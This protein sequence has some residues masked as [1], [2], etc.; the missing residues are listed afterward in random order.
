MKIIFDFDNTLFDRDG[1]MQAVAR[2]FGFS[3]NDFLASYHHHF[4][5]KNRFYHS[6]E[7]L[8]ILR[9]QEGASLEQEKKKRELDHLLEGSAEFLYSYSIPALRAAGDSGEEIF[10]LSEGDQEFQGAKINNCGIT[11]FFDKIMVTEDKIGSLKEWQG[12]R[13]IFINDKKEEN[14]RVRKEFSN[15][16]IYTVGNDP[17]DHQLKDIFALWN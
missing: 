6:Y 3:Y 14:E 11:P 12:E 1:F 7:H 10:L 2:I 8:R 17:D 16:E 4:K 5:E 9:E 13:F 15:V